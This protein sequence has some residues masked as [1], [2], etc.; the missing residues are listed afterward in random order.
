M[1][2]FDPGGVAGDDCASW[3]IFCYDAA[4]ADYRALPDGDPAEEGGAGAY[5][6]A[7]LHNGLLAVPVGF[8]LQGAVSGRSAGIAIVR[9]CHA[10]ADEDFVFKHDAFANE[11][12]AGDLA[13]L[14]DGRAFLDFDESADLCFVTDSAAVEINEGKEADV[15]TEDNVRRDALVERWI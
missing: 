7:F 3:D 12:M 6:G 1:S 13:A 5:G 8:R 4:G 11:R 9:E 14:A 2:A 15:F 10:V